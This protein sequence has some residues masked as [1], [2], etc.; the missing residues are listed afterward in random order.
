M[1]D[2]IVATYRIET[3]FPVEQAAEV[4]AGEQSSG[5]FVRLPGETDELKERFRARVERI[6]P[7]GET[8]RPSLPGGKQP[9]EGG[10]YRQAEVVVS[11]P[12]ENVG[13]NLPTLV[14]TVQGNLYEL[15]EFS[16][17][18]LLDIE[19]PEAWAEAYPGPQFAI[20]GTRRLTGVR[21]R[22]ILGT[23]IKPSIGLSVEATACL[24]GDLAEAGIDFIKD[25]EL[26]ANP[27]HSPL[28]ARVA[29]VMEVIDRH[30]EKT[31]KKVMFA[32]NITD[33]ID[34]MRRHHDTVLA[35]G[36]TCVMVSLNS[37]G[38]PAVHHLRK[39]CQLPIHGHRNGWGMFTRHPW[40][41]IEFRAYQ[42]LWRLVGIDHI[43]TNAF[44]NKFWEP[45]ESVLRSLQACQEPM[46]GLPPLMPALSSGQWGGQAPVTYEAIGTTDVMYLAGGGIHAHPDGPAAGMRAIRQAWDAA[47]AGIDLTDHAKDHSELANAMK[48]FGKGAFPH[49]HDSRA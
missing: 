9:P 21:D 36:G 17:L 28:P 2:R 31:G 43:H 16:G 19:L 32:F 39:Y 6:E 18:K 8:D 49:G 38:L 3:R 14:A 1:N 24:V 41:G 40:L 5:T 20:E 22:P 45:N 44:D 37:L 23:I 34:A 15:R 25:D 11:W 30:A 33:E 42:K 47:V 13:E 29:A 26:L 46:L 35:A 7:L 48:Q 12:R 10:S 4:L 27:P